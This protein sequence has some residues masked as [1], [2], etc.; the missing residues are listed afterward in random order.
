MPRL[1]AVSIRSLS[2]AR[3]ACWHNL[4]PVASHACEF[5]HD[6][7]RGMA[8][9]WGLL[10]ALLHGPVQADSACWPERELLGQRAEALVW[11]SSEAGQQPVQLYTAQGAPLARQG[12]QALAYLRGD[13]TGEYAFLPLAWS[14]Q[15]AGLAQ[16]QQANGQAVW[17]K[18][19]ALGRVQA[20][21]PMGRSGLAQPADARIAVVPRSAAATASIPAPAR[22]ALQV[23]IAAQHL[24]EAPTLEQVLQQRADGPLPPF[25]RQLT[26]QSLRRN[27]EG[28]W[29]RVQERLVYSPDDG[30]TRVLGP[31]VRSGYLLHRDGQGL[32]R[33]VVEDAWCD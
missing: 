12:C 18:P 16:A 3:F 20:L 22:Q 1:L 7:N 17:L 15:V 21:L 5:G 13:C 30:L 31:V 9:A 8:L 4:V 10:A 23:F 27:T 19:Q 2:F 28:T 14:T 32:V 6:R 26:V 33:A 24:P 29:A 11:G 25:F